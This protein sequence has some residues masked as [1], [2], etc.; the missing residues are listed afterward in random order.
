MQDHVIKKNRQI[1]RRSLHGT[2]QPEKSGKPKSTN[3][4]QLRPVSRKTPHTWQKAPGSNAGSI[5]ALANNY[6]SVKRKDSRN[7]ESLALVKNDLQQLT[8]CLRGP[9]KY[10]PLAC[11]PTMRRMS[12]E[13]RDGPSVPPSMLSPLET[14]ETAH[15]RM[16]WC[17]T[18]KNR[19]LH[20]SL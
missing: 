20:R 15:Q 14:F 19:R 17:S 16:P 4:T 2:S 10:Q 8:G 3:L 11:Q 7:R 5:L 6:L 9:H 1:A 13:T 12:A 18:N